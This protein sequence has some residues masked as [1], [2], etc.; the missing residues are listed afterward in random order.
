MTAGVDQV[1]LRARFG[2]HNLGGVRSL[3]RS[4]MLTSGLRADLAENLTTATAEG[5]ANAI[6]HGGEVRTVTV[7]VVGD[8]GV[9]AEVYD[10]G[11]AEAFGPPAQPPPPD[12][13][14]GRGLLMAHALCDRVSVITGRDGTVLM[15]EMDYRAA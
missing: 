3:V 4:A 7:S 14:G 10:D 8:V 1:L 13:E 2:L 5:M 12:R 9:I 15:L 11:H 6:T